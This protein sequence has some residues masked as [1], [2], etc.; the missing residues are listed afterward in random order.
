MDGQLREF[1]V[2]DVIVGKHM[3]KLMGA[4]GGR[5]DAY[6]AG[7]AGDR[8]ALDEAVRRNV[9]LRAGADDP[10]AV[11][12]GLQALARAPRSHARCRAAGG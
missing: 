11:A 2:G 5:L 12:D 9:T 3:G 10:A 7:L 4:M 8:A 6:R 1:G